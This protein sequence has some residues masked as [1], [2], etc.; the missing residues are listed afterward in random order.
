MRYLLL[1]LI[2]LSVI[3]APRTALAQSNEAILQRLDA[4]ERDNAALRRRV[5]IL[6]S[7]SLSSVGASVKTP[8][9][10]AGASKTAV[11]ANAPSPIVAEERS[12]DWSGPHVGAFAGLDGWSPSF[13]ASDYTP[14]YN[15]TTNYPLSQGA[16]AFGAIYGVK[17]GYDWQRGSLVLGIEGDLARASGG[18]VSSV[19]IVTGTGSINGVSAE[20]EMIATVRAR[21]GV[22]LDRTLI[23]LTAG[24]GAI[25]TKMINAIY[26]GRAFE[27]TSWVSAL[28][29]GTGI[30]YAIDAH[31]MVEAEGE[32][33]LAATNQANKVT[34]FI[35]APNI[36]QT[37]IVRFGTS[38][39]Q[40]LAKFGINYK[41]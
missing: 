8:P 32:Y 19:E 6:E 9:G 30:E 35:F 21:A 10:P 17:A 3:A 13:F 40:A 20:T 18:R 24:Y 29:L 27:D 37:A 28:A 22:A 2:G 14:A 25:E 7:R 38:P 34:T 16:T 33:L 23:Y 41:F 15:S 36:P 39:S 1:A 5:R 12:F 11:L 31:W 26:S 4:L